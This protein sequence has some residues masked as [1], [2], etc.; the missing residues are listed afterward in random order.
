MIE[1]DICA[2]ATGDFLVL[3]DTSLDGETTGRGLIR[4]C[5]PEEAHSL[6]LVHDGQVSAYSP[7]QLSEVVALFA[8]SPATSQLQLDFKDAYPFDNDEPFERLARLVAPLGNRV[9]VSSIADWQLHRLHQLRPEIRLGF[10]PQLYLDWRN[11][12]DATY[13]R[14]VGAYGYWD[15]APIAEARLWPTARYLADRCAALA[16]HVPGADMHFIRH[17]L[18]TQSLNDGF[19]WAEALAKEGIALAA[20]TLD[21]PQSQDAVRTLIQAGVTHLTTNTPRAVGEQLKV[22]SANGEG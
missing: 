22:E 21:L 15:D 4:A 10:D 19:N 3:H 13:P 18:L 2:L 14:R 1:I 20:W 8:T 6:K 9:I 16:R 17:G 11:A 7:P 12:N 5:T